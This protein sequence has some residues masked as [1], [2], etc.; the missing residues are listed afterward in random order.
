MPEPIRIAI[1]TKRLDGELCIV[2]P[3]RGLIVFAHGSGSSRYSRRNLNVA[4]TLQRRGFDTLLFDLLTT[5]EADDRT[6][7]FD[8]P[9]LGQRVLEALDALPASARD[10]PL[11]LFGASTGAA[12]ALVAA[13]SRPD[14]VQAVVS[15]GGRPDLA[16]GHLG[17]VR[18]ATLLIVGGSDP[19][20]L[21]LNRAAFALLRYEKR[22]DVVPRA[23]HLFEEAGA[24]ETVARLAG[25]WFLEHLRPAS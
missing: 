11:G 3:A 9:L 8:I 5:D 7:V 6:N 21:E 17:S 20:V 15:R 16:R 1:G 10:L 13:A 4:Q 2:E 22:I 18:A 23:T 19:E 14:R 12:A 24:L 25:D